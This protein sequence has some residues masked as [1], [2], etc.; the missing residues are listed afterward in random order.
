MNESCTNWYNL[1]IL[2]HQLNILTMEANKE[3]KRRRKYYR[4]THYPYRLQV[5][6]SADSGKEIEKLADQLEVSAVEVVRRAV[7][8]GLPYL[9]ERVRKQLAKDRKEQDRQV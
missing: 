1:V 7:T 4:P 8:V 3:P 5:S 2:I 6:H 9:K